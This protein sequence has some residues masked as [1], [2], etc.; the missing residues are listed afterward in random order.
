MRTDES[1]GSTDKI[2]SRDT[3]IK[4]LKSKDKEKYLKQQRKKHVLQ[5]SNDKSDS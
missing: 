5:E 1:N 3:I 2:K 4:L